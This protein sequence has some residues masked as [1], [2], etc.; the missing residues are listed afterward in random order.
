MKIVFYT[1]GTTG[2]GRIIKGI[3]I[4]NALKRK[5]IDSDYTILS[6]S[7]FGFLADKFDIEHIEIPVEHEKKLTG[8]C[9]DKSEL[10][11]TI[12]RLDPDILIVDLQW[13]TINGF[14]DDLPCKKIFLCTNLNSEEKANLYFNIPLSDRILRF[15]PAKYDLIVE[16]EPTFIPKP[17][18]SI[19]P[20]IIRNREEI[21]SKEDAIK[22]LEINHSNMVC[23]FAINGKPGEYIDALKTFSYLE[24]E[25]YNII[26]STNYEGGIFP[27]ADYFNA[28]DLIVTS[29]G[30]NS[31]WE[32]QYF[33]KEAIFI[34]AHRQFEDQK[35]RI[36]KC[37]GITF[38][39]N[40]ADQLV[41]I[42]MRST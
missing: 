19:N 38:E 18:L 22:Y 5:G 12:S 14:I 4:G 28:F 32:V 16:A 36:D 39:E 9:Y 3:S 31:F 11:C 7:S 42:M 25:G 37:S 2:S 41:E 27:V 40:G 15:N 6:S 13:F 34:P 17:K 1:S 26:Y 29:G 8:K 35:K 24:D 23:L 10:F 30:Y 33:K 21:F 20:L